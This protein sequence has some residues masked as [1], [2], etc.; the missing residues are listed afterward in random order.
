MVQ[1]FTESMAYLMDQP[2]PSGCHQVALHTESDD[3]FLEQS[4]PITGIDKTNL[5]SWS[6]LAR[7]MPWDT[8]RDNPPKNLK[9]AAIPHKNQWFCA[10][11]NLSFQI[12]MGRIPMPSINLATHKQAN[13]ASMHQLGKVLP[14]LITAMAAASPEHGPCFFAKWDIKDG[15][16]RMMVRNEDAWNFCYVLP[17]KQGEP[18]RLKSPPASRWVGANHHL[19]SVVPLKWYI[20]SLNT[21]SW[22]SRCHY[23][24][25]HW[26]T[27]AS[28][29][30]RSSNHSNHT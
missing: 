9:L 5:Q 23:P 2:P 3:A 11:L 25:T 26:K 20:T 30:P 16:W 19:S 7:L 10:I 29:C 1:L 27:Y 21:C 12:C 4:V 28:H 15:F 17:T 18:S 14:H 24:H 13:Q 8:I 6:G 22:T